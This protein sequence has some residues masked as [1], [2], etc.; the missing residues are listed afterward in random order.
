[1]SPKK[2]K[3]LNKLRRK[4]DLIDNKMLNLVGQRGRLV[5]RVLDLK[6]YK[7]QIVDRKRINQVLRRIKKMSIQKKI[8]SKV[9]NRIWKN[10]IAGFIDLQRKNFK[11]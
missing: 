7:N 3:K 4:L 11:K 9:S 5:K 2:L 1:M 6:Q 8:D 10:M